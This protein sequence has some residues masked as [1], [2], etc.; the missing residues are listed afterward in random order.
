MAAENEVYIDTRLRGVED[1]QKDLQKVEAQLGKLTDRMEKFREIGGSKDTKTYKGMQ[2]DYEILQDK[3][4]DLNQELAWF[5][6]HKG[7]EE[8]ATQTKDLDKACKLASGSV[9]KL[10]I[11]VK[12]NNSAFLD[13]AKKLLIYAIGIR[14]VFSAIR[15]IKQAIGEGL[16]NLAQFNDGVNP[17][18][19]AISGLQSSLTN[20]KNSLAT[21]FAPIL[22][23][24]AP[25]LTRLADI[26]SNVVTQVGMLIAKLTGATTFTK[27]TKV[28]ED[29][30]KSLKNTGKAAEEAN[31]K[32]ASFDELNVMD[33]DKNA[34]GGGYTAPSAN[35][36]FETVEIEGNMSAFAERMFEIISNVKDGI[37][38]WFT[39]V[40]FQ[41]LVDAFGKLKDAVL[42]I[43]DKIGKGITWLLENVL[44][45]LSKFFIEN[46]LPKAVEV[47]S[48]AFTMLDGVITGLTP[49]FE[50]IW[51]NVIKP[52]GEFAG[53]VFVRFL[54]A[55]KKL[56]AD[57]ATV[58]TE[59]GEKIKSIFELIG[60]AIELVWT[61]YFKPYFGFIIGV[62]AGLLEAVGPII[63]DVIDILGGLCDFLIGVFTFDWERAWNGIKSIFGGVWNFILDVFQGVINTIISG[64]NMI[65]IDVPDWVPGI[66]GL[67]FGF[68][69]PKL[70]LKAIKIPALATGTVVPASSKEFMAM[71]GDNNAETEVV[72]PLST[73][74]QAFLEA[75]AE[76]GFSGNANVN[77]YLEGNAKGLFRVV[78]TEAADYFRSTG[79]NALVF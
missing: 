22:T 6:E 23:A 37:K 16:K 59:K 62:F 64:L 71:L 57:V 51:E 72:S 25:V 4:A 26:I 35:E 38:D 65:S 73:M 67:K 39:S 66:G 34:S 55:I 58:F 61:F 70:D 75:M 33:E 43:V 76:S 63:G 52:I 40:N 46:I 9:K 32:L 8:Q 69:I 11:S 78:R 20:L 15:K 56:F 53:E 77:V 17:V 41:P 10:G 24:V 74:K 50:Y 36:M 60:K 31:S 27:A 29:Y 3:L 18:N 1:V 68:N 5:D 49:A 54:D 45:P 12:K 21:A 19:T 28:Q 47:L 48:G 13:G 30:A 7:M 44:G 2:Y 79:N 14:S 42:P